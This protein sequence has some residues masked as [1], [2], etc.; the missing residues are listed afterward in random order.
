MSKDEEYAGMIN[1]F[2]KELDELTTVW[3]QEEQKTSLMQKLLSS[4]FMEVHDL[5]THQEQ[6]KGLVSEN[7]KEIS[8]NYKQLRRETVV[9]GEDITN[10]LQ[11]GQ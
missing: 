6:I 9:L 7:K 10:Q 5:E 2:K 1:T 8:A 11:E 4:L 3:A